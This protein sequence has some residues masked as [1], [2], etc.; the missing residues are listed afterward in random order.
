MDD[1][2]K[3]ERAFEAADDFSQLKLETQRIIGQIRAVPYGQ[4]ASYKEIGNL[5]G[6]TNGS[7]QVARILHSLSEKYELPWWRII[8]SDRTL[9][10]TGAARVEQIRLLRLENVSVDDL[11]HVAL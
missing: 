5:A 6:L 10:L 11:G 2:A 1:F 4:V 9:G 8:K 3:I 7:R